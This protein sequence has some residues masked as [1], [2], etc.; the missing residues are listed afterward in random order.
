MC[1]EHSKNVYKYLTTIFGSKLLSVLYKIKFHK[2]S[3][4]IIPPPLIKRK[5]INIKLYQIQY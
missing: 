3:I 5:H 2:S 1:L 4:V